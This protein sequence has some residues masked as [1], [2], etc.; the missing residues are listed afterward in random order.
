MKNIPY[1]QTP[2]K[3]KLWYIY[4]QIWT[5][6]F[7]ICFRVLT[8]LGVFGLFGGTFVLHLFEL[9]AFSGLE[10]ELS[11]ELCEDLLEDSDWFGV[12]LVKVDPD[13]D[14]VAGWIIDLGRDK[15]EP[16]YL[17]ASVKILSKQEESQLLIDLFLI[18]LC[19]S[20]LENESSSLLILLILP[21]GLNSLFEKLNGVDF[22]LRITNEVAA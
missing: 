19:F 12:R 22:F 5:S 11:E 10:L 4:L 7:F 17:V 15:T 14:S 2:D 21:F 6:S 3:I 20:N 18:G 16:I 8:F 1:L 13:L 9:D